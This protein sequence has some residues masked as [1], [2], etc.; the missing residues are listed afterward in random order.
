MAS[1]SSSVLAATPFLGYIVTEK[2]SRN[3]HML[4]KAQVLFVIKC[5][6][7]AHFLISATLIPQK[8]IA[9]SPDKPNE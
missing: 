1:H 4:W 5:A 3:N 2:L 9:K 7:V 8:T 6:Q